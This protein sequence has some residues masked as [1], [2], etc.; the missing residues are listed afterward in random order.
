MHAHELEDISFTLLEKH[1]DSLFRTPEKAAADMYKLGDSKCDDLPCIAFQLKSRSRSQVNNLN[2]K[3]M[4][5]KLIKIRYHDLFVICTVMPDEDPVSLLSA[6]NILEDGVPPLERYLSERSDDQQYCLLFPYSEI[7]GTISIQSD[8][9]FHDQSKY[10][11]NMI[12]FS[13]LGQVLRNLY[14]DIFAGK[15]SFLLPNGNEIDISPLML[16]LPK[17]LY[18]M[19][20]ETTEIEQKKMFVLRQLCRGFPFHFLDIKQSMTPGD[21]YI[22]DVVIQAK[23]ANSLLKD[24]YSYSLKLKRHGGKPYQMYHFHALL[25]HI[26]DTMIYGIIPMPVLFFNG[27]VYNGENRVNTH[28]SVNSDDHPLGKRWMFDFKYPLEAA[29]KMWNILEFVKRQNRK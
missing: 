12:E 13:K 8:I 20:D 18:R 6:N 26:N 27:H 17:K 4:F 29:T 28:I 1:V 19:V 25:F 15:E 22:N 21:Y 7:N 24:E 14:N 10:F 16:H 3:V 2:N 23:V 5:D 11:G 9:K